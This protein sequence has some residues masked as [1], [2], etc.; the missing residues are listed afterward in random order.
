MAA[1]GLSEIVT[2][3]LLNR[4]K[5][6]ADNVTNNNA[7]LK[8]LKMR[9]NVK[10]FSGGTEIVEELS[11]AENQ[12]YKRYSGFERLNI[13]PS[14]V[15]S[16]AKYQ[17]RQAAVAVTM[18]GLEELQNAGQERMIDLL[19]SRIENAQATMSNNLS[20]DVY[21]DGTA[22]G[23]KQVDGLQS[24]ISTSPTT[25]TVGGI[26]RANFTFWRNIAP[27]SSSITATNIQGKMRAVWV[28]LVRGVDKTDL[29]TADNNL[30]TLFWESM[31]ERQRFT[32]EG[33]MAKAGW[34]SL[35]FN[36]AE[37]VLD[38]GSGGSAPSDSMYFLNTKYIKFRPHSKRNMRPMDK[39]RYSTDQDAMVQLI[40]W[41]GNLCMRNA[42]LQG[43]LKGT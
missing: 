34:D 24:Q 42:K 40:L 1:P 43:V 30:Y 38:G 9:G 14:E 26:N 39:S 3:T 16:A 33:N 10:T 5:Q 17:I 13:A 2:T 11:Y 37:V 27:A 36:T 20:A 22:N 7:L 21:S 15:L 8:K 4:S 23:G 35:K 31:S 28:Q 18:S 41:A 29:I 6:L 25:G 12:T 32:S 19:A